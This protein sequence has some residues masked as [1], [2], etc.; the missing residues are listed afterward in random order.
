MSYGSCVSRRWSARCGR[1]MCVFA[2]VTLGAPSASATEVITIRSGQV[3]NAPGL[4]GQPD[5]SITINPWGNPNI[6]PVLNTAFTPA[7]FAATASGPPAVVV[8]PWITCMGGVTAPL[9]DPLARWVNFTTDNAG[10]GYGGSVLYA[11]PFYINTTTITNATVSFEGGTDDVL[12]DWYSND[13]P[14][15]D[16]LY[17]NGNPAGYQYQGFNAAAP[18]THTQNITA[19]VN[20]GQNYLY[21]YQRD[22]GAGAGGII[23]SGTITVTPTPQVVTV[24]ALASLTATR[25]RRRT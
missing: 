1:A 8:N 23:F 11:V 19:M 25:R 5:D 17:I 6:F 10:Y 13:G 21:F 7:D 24:L 14:N 16:G 15:L 2:I 3:G 18:T 9:S 12:G 4:S 20:P 22:L